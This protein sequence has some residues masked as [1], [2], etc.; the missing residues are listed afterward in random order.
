MIINKFVK[1]KKTKINSVYVLLI[2]KCLVMECM[3]LY[4]YIKYKAME[5]RYERM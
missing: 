3:H 5:G 1:N 4:I 2:Y